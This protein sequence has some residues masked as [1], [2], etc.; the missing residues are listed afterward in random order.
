MFRRSE[1]RK[2]AVSPMSFGVLETTKRNAA[3]EPRPGVLLFWP[4]SLENCA[5]A[6]EC[7]SV[8]RMPGWIELTVMLCAASSE[9]TV[10]HAGDGK[11]RS[12]VGQHH[13]ETGLADNRRDDDAAALL[14]DHALHEG[15]RGQEQAARIDIHDTVVLFVGRVLHRPRLGRRGIVD[16]DI[17]ATERIQSL[18]RNASKTRRRNVMFNGDHPI[19]PRS[20][21]FFPR[22]RRRCRPLQPKRRRHLIARQFQALFRARRPVTT[23]TRPSRSEHAFLH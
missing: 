18:W 21:R 2:A 10:R 11:F 8:A 1:A 7:S 12:H 16:E 9:A 20:L 17:D 3:H 14:I 22:W 15:A 4:C 19:A 6:A 5:T 13:R 23:A